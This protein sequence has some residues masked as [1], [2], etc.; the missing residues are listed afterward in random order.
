LSDDVP[1]R[2]PDA[3][4][5]TYSRGGREPLSR[6][7]LPH[8]TR[9]ITNRGSLTPWGEHMKTAACSGPPFGHRTWRQ[10]AS[11]HRRNDELCAFLDAGRPARGDRLGLRVEAEGIRAVLVQV[12]EG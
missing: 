3:R 8:G 11:V 9:S 6:S 4:A 10:E 5:V 12:A 7:I 1:L 2:P